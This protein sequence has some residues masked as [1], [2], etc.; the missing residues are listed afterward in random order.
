MSCFML[1]FFHLSSKHSSLP[2]KSNPFLQTQ[3]LKLLQLTSGFLQIFGSKIQECF[4]TFFQNNN[5]FSQTQ[6]YQTGD[7]NRP[8]KTQEQS[9]FRYP[10]FLYT[11]SLYLHSVCMAL[12]QNKLMLL[13]F[14]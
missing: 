14:S 5:F 7:Q 2:F 11:F 13:K 3:P 8:L 6:G 12:T 10:M 4:H 9:S 1:F